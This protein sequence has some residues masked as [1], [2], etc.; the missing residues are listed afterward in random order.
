MS[1]RAPWRRLAV[2]LYQ[3][4]MGARVLRQ[5]ETGQWDA[6][7]RVAALE[8]T[9]ARLADVPP[10]WVIATA[11]ARDALACAGRFLQHPGTLR[12]CPLTFVGTYGWHTGEFEWVDCCE[13]GWPVS[14]VD[15]G[16][17]LW[18]RAWPVQS[19]PTIID[20]AHRLEPER[21]GRLLKTTSIKAVT[22]SFG[23]T[24]EIPCW[25]GGALISPHTT[26]QW[27]TWLRGGLPSQGQILSGRKGLMQE[28][29][30]VW[31]QAQLKRREKSHA[32]R[33]AI[34]ETYAHY[35][36]KTL[37]TQ[38]GEASGHLAVLRLPDEGQTMLIKRALTRNN[39]EHSVHYSLM[40]QSSSACPTAESLSNRL[41][42]IPCH[43]AMKPADVL[44]V[45]RVVQSA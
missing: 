10:E 30:A 5:L 4:H 29:E 25:R 43:S 24:K 13:D 15:V 37:V 23:P 9:L 7:G 21:H 32:A 19:P 6:A 39:V 11:S 22:Y 14:S 3:P 45:V 38:P 41:I 20:A 12:V 34:L 33:Q 17:E 44:R 1:R 42:S 28:P 31:I 27:R 26:E 18:G 35:L 2:P 8:R 40:A 36:G 16:V